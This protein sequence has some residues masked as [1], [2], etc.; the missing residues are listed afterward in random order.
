MSTTYDF[1][2]KQLS[3][4]DLFKIAAEYDCLP[5]LDYH[6][7]DLFDHDRVSQLNEDELALLADAARRDIFG[8]ALA[9]GYTPEREALLEQAHGLLC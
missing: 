2:K 3:F 4:L 9:Q 1:T 8:E 6:C 5:L 7:M